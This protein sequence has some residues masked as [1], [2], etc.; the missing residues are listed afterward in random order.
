MMIIIRAAYQQIHQNNT[1][2][3]T[4]FHEMPLPNSLMRV[5][6][7]YAYTLTIM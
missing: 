7:I 5:F 2:G 1:A 3:A 6:I 4:Y